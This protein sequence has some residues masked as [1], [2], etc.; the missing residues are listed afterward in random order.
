MITFQNVLIEM[1]TKNREEI[2]SMVKTHFPDLLRM[3]K[4]ELTAEVEQLKL[5]AQK[6]IQ[7]NVEKLVSNIN[8]SGKHNQASLTR[9]SG[10]DTQL[11]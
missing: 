8:R 1:L 10:I 2:N 5:I 7:E 9:L 4:P 3:F 6:T 11:Q